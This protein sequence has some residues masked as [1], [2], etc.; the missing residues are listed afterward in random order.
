MQQVSLIDLISLLCRSYVMRV[1]VH[2]FAG[3][4]RMHEMRW[5]SLAHPRLAAELA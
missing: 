2:K 3:P 1:V 5:C 4:C